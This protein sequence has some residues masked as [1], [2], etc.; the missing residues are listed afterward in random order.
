MF[1]VNYLIYCGVFIKENRILIYRV[2]EN[3]G[4]VLILC[5]LYKY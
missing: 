3:I 1:W 5:F 2:C 4:Y